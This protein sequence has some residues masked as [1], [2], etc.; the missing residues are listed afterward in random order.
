M[1]I[2]EFAGLGFSHLS[3]CT[4]WIKKHHYSGYQY[5]LIMDP[6]L[7][8]DLI[9]GIDDITDSDALL[10]EVHG[11]QVQNENRGTPEMKRRL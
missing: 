10:A 11:G 1:C 7:M 2:P 4:D 3:D 6:L 5:G 8:L 9:F